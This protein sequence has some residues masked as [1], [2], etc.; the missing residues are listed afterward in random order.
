MQTHWMQSATI[1]AGS[2][3][4]SHREDYEIGADVPHY[5]DRSGTMGFTLA[6]ESCVE[7]SVVLQ[8]NGRI[9][10]RVIGDHGNPAANAAIGLFDAQTNKEVNFST[11]DEDGKYTLEGNRPGDYVVGVNVGP[12]PGQDRPYA[13]I[14]Y[15]SAVRRE[16]AGTIHLDP[17]HRIQLADIV[18]S[19]QC[20][21][22]I[23][24]LDATGRPVSGATLAAQVF[25]HDHFYTL[26]D[27]EIVNDGRATVPTWG[28]DRLQILA[29]LA[30]NGDLIQS[31]PQWIRLCPKQP[32]ILR[33]NPVEE[34]KTP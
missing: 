14:F 8:H 28:H 2:A 1:R 15:P 20:T 33:L 11:A 13:P 6:P 26:Y 31:Q 16:D 22:A 34:P 24:V 19:D 29:S 9:E 21:I 10:G 18:T 5:F 30:V 17:G 32:V 12:L 27:P 7:A 25:D 23:R 4:T 3:E